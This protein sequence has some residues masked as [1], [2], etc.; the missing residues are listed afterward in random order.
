MTGDYSEY[1]VGIEHRRALNKE[2]GDISK[3]Y[4]SWLQE[5]E[6]YANDI[7]KSAK[8]GQG[9]DRAVGE[10]IMKVII[11][12]RRIWADIEREGS[13]SPDTV[14][15]VAALSASLM[16]FSHFGLTLEGKHAIHRRRKG[17]AKGAESKRAE[18]SKR[19]AEILK[20]RVD[21]QTYKAIAERFNLSEKQVGRICRKNS[22]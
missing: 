16:D 12:L 5:L 18:T 1:A 21:G 19:D 7:L 2:I 9:A 10:A 22:K 11:P 6:V 14:E 4:F 17:G 13:A 20:A 8:S 3:G 15:V